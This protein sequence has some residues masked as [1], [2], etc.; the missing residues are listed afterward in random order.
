MAVS[1]RAV[2]SCALP[3]AAALACAL[4]ALRYIAPGVDLAAMAR[5][6]V[7]PATW[8]R[9]MLLSAAAAAA[10]L[11]LLRLFEAL[12]LRAR[13]ERQAGA[14]PDYHEGRS[15]GAIGLLLAYGAATPLV[16][17]ALATPLFI[18]AWLLLGGLRRPLAVALASILGTVGVLYFFVKLSLMPLERGRGVFEQATLALYRLLGIY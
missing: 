18:A 4:L 17:F 13:R 8:P 9:A 2:L 14:A 12:G 1:P 7:G 3:A 16:G 6:I 5:G 11:A 10:L 15:L